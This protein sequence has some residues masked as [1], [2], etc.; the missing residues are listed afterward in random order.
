VYSQ[1]NVKNSLILYKARLEDGGVY[2]CYGTKRRTSFRVNSTI[3]IGSKFESVKVVGN[4][5]SNIG[6]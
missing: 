2:V 4:S 6:H 3:L 1:E 5:S